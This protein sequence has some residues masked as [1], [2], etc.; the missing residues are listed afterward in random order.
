MTYSEDFVPVD[1]A[2]ELDSPSYPTAFGV[3]LT[4]KIQG[5][6][7]ALLGVVGAF[8]L[9]TRIVQPIQE[10]KAEL[11]QRVADK[12]EIFENQDESLRRI[13]AVQADLDRALT[14]REGIY[15]LLGSPDSLDT[16]LF[17]I[18]QQIQASNASIEAILASDLSQVRER[19]A[20]GGATSEQIDEFLVTTFKEVL[21]SA[22]T[23]EGVDEQIDQ[24]F[25]SQFRAVLAA[26]GYSET[27]IRQS[28]L[29]GIREQLTTARYTEE[30]IETILTPPIPLA[31]LLELATTDL[32]NE[33]FLLSGF[34]ERLTSD[35]Y[36]DAQI[37]QL[38]D[39]VLSTQLLESLLYSSQLIEFNPVGLSGPVADEFGTELNSKLERQVVEVQFTALFPQTQ[40]IVNNIERLEPLVIIRDFNQSLVTPPGGLDEEQ[41]DL[42][43]C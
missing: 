6:G 10:R 11:E 34:R 26:E 13:E 12:Q 3:E 25:Y 1:D 24:V 4:P 5:I 38:V 28:L 36:S 17:D 27:Q 43:Y 9:F 22:G 39:Q 29:P 2:Q 19:L 31:D 14:Q 23:G 41:I 40:T 42:Y 15:S 30:Q 8:F 16:I 37:G 35:G 7:I 21:T 33:L 18:N 20:P 32:E